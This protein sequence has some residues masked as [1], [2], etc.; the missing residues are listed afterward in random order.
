[1]YRPAQN[2]E[3]KA[4]ATGNGRAGNRRP[5]AEVAPVMRNSAAEKGNAGRL[6]NRTGREAWKQ[7]ERKGKSKGTKE[8]GEH[9]RTHCEGETGRGERKKQRL[10]SQNLNGSDR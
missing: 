3:P 8:T 7:A 6:S 5:A 2:P 9:R 4:K 10:S 1:M